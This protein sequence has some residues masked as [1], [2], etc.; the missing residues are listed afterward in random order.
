MS[1]QLKKICIITE[2]IVISYY[3]HY[4]INNRK[5]TV[6]TKQSNSTCGTII[7]YIIITGMKNNCKDN[8]VVDYKE[9][10]IIVVFSCV[11]F[12]ILLLIT[13][14]IIYRRRMFFF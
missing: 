7:T 14:A 3:R 5:Y 6:D 10:V 1:E 2:Q 13:I 9:K 11:A 4:I 8:D 12:N